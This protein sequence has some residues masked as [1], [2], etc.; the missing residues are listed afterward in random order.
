MGINH[1]FE[2][3][4]GHIQDLADDRVLHYSGGVGVGWGLSGGEIAGM[5]ANCL[6]VS[7]LHETIRYLEMVEMGLLKDIEYIEFRV[8]KEGCIGGPF[9]VVDR[10]Q[11]KRLV[12]K[13]VRMFGEE[14]RIKYKYVIRLYEEGWFSSDRDYA[15]WQS[16]PR[17]LSGSEISDHIKRQKTVERVFQSLPGK[18]CGACGSPDCRTFAED[19]VD[20][21]ASPESCF[22]IRERRTKSALSGKR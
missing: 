17:Q 18:E 12:Q 5:N 2:T 7:G 22:Y 21:R 14:K 10:Y 9:A 6:A 8:C 15:P 1:V 11:S 20:R 13:L 4:K 19:V 16:T 3:L